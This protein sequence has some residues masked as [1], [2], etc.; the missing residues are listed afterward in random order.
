MIG[1]MASISVIVTIIL[2]VIAS[3]LKYSLPALGSLGLAGLASIVG[4]VATF[5]GII[6]GLIGLYS[7]G[8]INEKIE[9]AIDA[10]KKV[11]N[12]QINKQLS[13]HMRAVAEYNRG[14]SES[15]IRRASEY[16]ESALRLQ[17][18]LPLVS[19]NIGTRFA[20]ATFRWA[21]HRIDRS[22]GF[23]VRLTT[24]GNLDPD[25]YLEEGD[26]THDAIRWLEDV[27]EVDG[28]RN[29]HWMKLAKLYSLI[30]D[31]RK[32]MSSLQHAFNLSE[33]TTNYGVEDIGI[34]LW[35]CSDAGQVDEICKTIHYEAP[36]MLTKPILKSVLTKE[37]RYEGTMRPL[38]AVRRKGSMMF[39]SEAPSSPTIYYVAKTLS[40]N[41]EDRYMLQWYGEDVIRY[42]KPDDDPWD[43][44]KLLDVVNDWF[45]TVGEV[46]K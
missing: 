8:S 39:K 5:G 45:I 41:G 24:Y 26:Y 13:I 30:G 11:W 9:A 28:E 1:W 20:E 32:M 25:L 29:M 36:I 14:L 3:A 38:L 7:L 16:M 19:E 27:R 21:W 43:V 10:E 17:P 44:D 18:E 4:G 40:E 6:T 23:N 37:R 22:Q 12:S 35:N 15:D 34:L 33:E 46:Y 42:P 31:H 2:L